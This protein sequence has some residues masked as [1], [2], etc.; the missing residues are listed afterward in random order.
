MSSIHKILAT[1]ILV[2]ITCRLTAQDCPQE[3]APCPDATAIGVAMDAVTRTKNNDVFLQ[4]MNM[5][6]KVRNLVTDEVRRIAKVNNWSVYELN[7]WGPTSPSHF[8]ISFDAWEATPFNKRPP[9]NYEISFVFILN[10][11]SLHAWKNWLVNDVTKQSSQVVQQYDQSQTNPLLQQYMDS[12][13]YYME[14]C[15]KYI[16]DNNTSYSKDIQNK[17]QKGIDA[18]NRKKNELANKSKIFQKKLEEAQKQNYTGF[19]TFSNNIGQKSVA[20]AESSIAL[21]HFYI[22]RYKSDFVLTNGQQIS[23]LPQHA[24]TIPHAFY[25]GITTNNVKPD[26]QNYQLTTVG[27]D[28]T[29]PACIATVLFGNYL[30]KDSYNNY[31]ASFSKNFKNKQGVIGEIKQISCDKIQNIVVHVEGASRPV[32]TII[33]TLDWKNLYDLL[34]VNNNQLS[35][36]TESK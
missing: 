36:R 32:N 6:N 14:L 20:F 15:L 33:N 19:A 4:E 10:K 18:Y 17:N 21:I 22:N 27:F 28:F 16:S 13:N 5:E 35:N 30:P 8:F 2:S 29:N 24:I 23:I 1:V 9:H 34:Y 3:P 11:D 31:P 7:E 26:R 25:A 12:M